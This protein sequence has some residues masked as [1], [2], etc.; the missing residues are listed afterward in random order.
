MDFELVKKDLQVSIYGRE[1]TLKKPT[2]FQAESLGEKLEAAGEGKS[3]SV[4]REFLSSLGLP[5][6]LMAELAADDFVKLCEFLSGA[7][8][9]K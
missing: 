6:D 3:I 1:L 2:I 7:V 8:K 9:K 5:E 4:M